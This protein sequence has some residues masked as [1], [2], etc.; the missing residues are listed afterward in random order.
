[1]RVRRCMHLLL[2][3]REKASFGIAAILRGRVEVESEVSWV[4]LAAH[5]E[6]PVVVD[7]AEHALLGQVSAHRWQDLSPGISCSPACMRLL[8]SGLLLSEQFEHA[9]HLF[10]DNAIRDT[11]WW[12]PAAI[13]HRHSRWQGVDSV[14]DMRSQRLVTASDLRRSLGP[15]PSAVQKHEGVYTPL[16]RQMEDEFDAML[17]RR[18][19]CRNFDRDRSLPLSL[20]AQLL[21]RGMMAQAEFEA[22]PDT[23]FLK[24]NVPS[25][26]GLH[27][28][29]AYLLVQNVDGLAPG[30]YHYHPLEHALLQLPSPAAGEMARLA[31][32]ALSGQDWFA[33]APA[34]IVLAPR[35]ERCFWK[36]RN[37][38]K[39]YRAVLFDVGHLSQML[40]LCATEAGLGAFV[41]A[42]IN[43]AD[44]DQA[45]GLDGI[46]QGAVAIFGVGW[47]SARQET[48][49]F[50]PAHRV[51]T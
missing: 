10:R 22:A 21:Q 40:Y 23:V 20:L 4:A 50:D 9:E 18:A 38:S 24:K 1:M 6:M 3:P 39:A 51:W 27:P 14:G 7:A 11:H 49:E 45:L 28:V 41:T 31:C 15:P 29:E 26:G 46:Q 8:E 43:E 32:T 17:A 13:V 35:F 47:R 37:H 16:P 34:M 19:T 36:Y 33:G 5:L 42:A 44:L 30:L 48:T 12:S 25:G 2:E